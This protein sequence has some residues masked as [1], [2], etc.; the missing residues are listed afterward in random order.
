MNVKLADA[1]K[2]EAVQSLLTPYSFCVEFV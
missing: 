2:L 1:S